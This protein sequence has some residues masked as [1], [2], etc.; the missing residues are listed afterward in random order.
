[1]S[2]TVVVRRHARERQEEALVT[3]VAAAIA[4]PHLR[5][6]AQAWL[7]QG[8]DDPRAVLAVTRWTDRQEYRAHNGASP[9]AIEALCDAPPQ[10]AFYQ[11]LDLIEAPTI[12]AAVLSCVI[13]QAPPA[14]TAA[15]ITY[16]FE[17]SGPALLA[18][19]GLALRAIYQDMDVP[20]RL[21]TLLGWRTPADQEAARRFLAP[22]L[23]PPLRD[24]GATIERFRDRTPAEADRARG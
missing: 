11:Q 15:V 9:R 6:S 21:F 22:L 12:P 8:L 1:M 4:P 18:A 14:A 16:L 17:R 20:S 5:A 3:A 10:H 24:L 13:V 2:V 7:F 23:D 19:P